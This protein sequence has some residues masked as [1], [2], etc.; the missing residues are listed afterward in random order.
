MLRLILAQTTKKTNNSFLA[1]KVA[2]RSRNIPA[3]PV[4]VL[5]CFAGSGLIWAAVKRKTGRNITVLPIDKLGYGG[6]YLPGDNSTFLAGLDLRK[7]DVI[8][9]DSYGVP[10]EQLDIIHKRGFTGTLFVTFIQTSYGAITNGLLESVGFTENQIVKA[11]S[12]FA[13]RGWKYFLELL[14]L[15]GVTEIRHRSHARK[16]YLAFKVSWVGTLSNRFSGS[17]SN[18]THRVLPSLPARISANQLS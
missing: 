17:R 1:D 9:L 8:D 5:D 18:R 13:K 11:P 14:A 2:L 7:F 16:H 10:F 6:F 12:L 4:R 15:W 3:G